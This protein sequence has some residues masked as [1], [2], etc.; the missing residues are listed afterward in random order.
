MTALAD[1]HALSLC[2]ADVVTG[3]LFHPFQKNCIGI[4]QVDGDRVPKLNLFI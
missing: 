4:C 1:N 3:L 2:Q